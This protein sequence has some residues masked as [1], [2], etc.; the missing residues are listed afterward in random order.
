MIVDVA[1]VELHE[2]VWTLG[3]VGNNQCPAQILGSLGSSSLIIGVS[4]RRT[5][6]WSDGIRITIGE[7]R[8]SPKQCLAG[9]CQSS[10]T[11]NAHLIVSRSGLAWSCLFPTDGEQLSSFGKI[12]SD[13]FAAFAIWETWFAKSLA[14]IEHLVNIGKT[15]KILHQFLVP[16]CTEEVELTLDEVT[17]LL[18][19]T[20][21]QCKV[22]K[23]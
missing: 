13:A 22:L 11:G 3:V 9:V 15:A 12:G 14:T 7:W 2:R 18:R 4:V 17:L 10:S 19:G 21:H 8:C 16:P 1:I 5:W 23:T 20:G 6:L